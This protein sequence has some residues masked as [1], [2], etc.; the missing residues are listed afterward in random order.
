MASYH[1]HLTQVKRSRGQSVIAQA[2]YRAGEK[3]YST[4]YGESSDFTRKRGVVMAEICLPDHAPREYA[5]RET[6]W[7]A[8]E[9]AE[10]GRKAQLAHSFDI[11]LMNEFSM[12]ENIEMARAFVQEELV[13]RGMIA[14][15]AIHDPV[16][17][18]GAEPNP[19]IH[20]LVPIR[21]LKEDGTWGIKEKKISVMDEQRNP[22]FDKNGKQAYRAVST[23]GWSSKEMLIY[24]RKNWENRCNEKFK[25]KGLSVRVDAR[26]FKERGI[27]RIPMIHEGPHVRAMEAKGIRT[28]LGNLNRLISQFNQIAMEITVLKSWISEKIYELKRQMHYVQKPTLAGYLQQ[29]YDERNRVARTYQ[30]GSQK[31]MNTNLKQLAETIAFL[32]DENIDT[33]EELEQRI[34][35]LSS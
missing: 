27:D 6:L 28:A 19:H 8:L 16:R 17:P 4:Y 10:S 2:A 34:Q 9:W 12:E 30:Y 13:S 35:E 32:S 11:T 21:P 31:A 24:L 25:E 23:T 22:V 18:K 3:L 29:Y 7:N 1:F 20:I 5:D 26:S 33:P 14:D 15:F